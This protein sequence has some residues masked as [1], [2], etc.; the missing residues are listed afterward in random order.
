[1]YLVDTNIWLERLL[2]QDR[3]VEV[4]RFLEVVPSK[5]LFITDFAF[6]SIGVIL[7]RLNKSDVLLLFIRDLFIEGSVSLVHLEPQE[8]EK[9]VEAMEKFGLD[10]D[11]AYQYVAADLHGLTLI[12]FDSDFERT[13]RPG[14]TPLQAI[15][16][17]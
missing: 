11:D 14:K 2:E 1:V 17:K 15:E 3:S 12:S 13:D 10:F 6:H 4:G 5:E 9:V 16:E 7:G 8:V